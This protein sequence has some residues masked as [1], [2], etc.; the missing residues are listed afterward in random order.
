MQKIESTFP[1]LDEDRARFGTPFRPAKGSPLAADDRRWASSPLSQHAWTCL[2]SAWDHF[3]LAR[4]TI[5]QRRAFPTAVF[6]VLRGALLASSQGLWLVV[7]EDPN[8]RQER[9]LIFA[10]EWYHRR[11]QWQA[12]LTPDLDVESAVVSTAQL[13]LLSDHL[14]AVK[15]LRTTKAKL[16]PTKI[17]ELAGKATFAEVPQQR[18]IVRE[19]RRLGGDA[20]GLGWPLLG[21]DRTWGATGDDGLT[22]AMVGASLVSVA[23]AYLGAWLIYRKGLKRLDEVARA[24]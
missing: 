16:E 6:S 24:E 23:N 3:D 21:Q 13:K 2:A 8:V 22:E 1:K 9:G 19:W 15:A 7:E 20:H 5:E 14:A 11:I 17:I 4:L 18:E 12:E 10:Q